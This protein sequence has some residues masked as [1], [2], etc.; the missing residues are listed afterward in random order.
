[1][2]IPVIS[3][4][5]SWFRR[6]DGDDLYRPSQRLI[7]RYFDGKRTVKADPLILYKRLMEVSPEL[8]IDA[9]VSLSDLKDA[10]K[11]HDALIAKV[12]KIFDLKP[13]CDGGLTQVEAINLLVHFIE[14]TGMLKKNSSPP[15]TSAT[16]QS[17]P[18]ESSQEK[19]PLTDSGLDSGS[20]GQESTKDVLDK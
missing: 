12:Q 3:W 8:S 1:M 6:S 2:A 5:A 13:L 7:Y 4:L 16:V 19:N 18:T 9:K 17:L 20:T 11:A 14:Y 15:A 10:P